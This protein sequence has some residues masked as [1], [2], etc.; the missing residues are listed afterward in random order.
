MP[1]F[2][3]L[4]LCPAYNVLWNCSSIISIVI[5]KALWK[6]KDKSA[7]NGPFLVTPLSQYTAK[8]F[9]RQFSTGFFQGG[10]KSGPRCEQVELT[11]VAIH[12][13]KWV[14]CFEISGNA[15]NNLRTKVPKMGLFL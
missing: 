7:K 10:S 9:L 2:Q 15:E 6:F 8:Y 11:T 3:A 13:L 4:S 1:K 14:S 5:Q 12:K